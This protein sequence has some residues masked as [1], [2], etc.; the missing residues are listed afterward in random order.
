MAFLGLPPHAI[1]HRSAL[2]LGPRG[3][4]IHFHSES[5][6]P[7]EMVEHHGDLNHDND[8]PRNHV[9]VTRWFILRLRIIAFR[10]TY[11]Q[12]ANHSMR[13]LVYL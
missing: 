12:K 7:A 2:G 4:Q 13:F 10:A 6:L 8:L 11:L 1:W 9:S 3:C 5:I